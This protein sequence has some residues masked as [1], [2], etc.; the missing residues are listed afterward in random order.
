MSFKTFWKGFRI[1]AILILITIVVLFMYQNGLIFTPNHTVALVPTSL[2]GQAVETRIAQSTIHPGSSGEGDIATTIPNDI[3]LTMADADAVTKQL[4]RQ[5]TSK[6][7]DL[8]LA[9]NVTV[10]SAYTYCGAA[11]D[12]LSGD[13]PVKTLVERWRENT[14][15]IFPG[16]SY[17]VIEMGQGDMYAGIQNPPDVTVVFEEGPVV[18]DLVAH[19]EVHTTTI[20]IT[21]NAVFGM[22]G[23]EINPGNQKSAS[24]LPEPSQFG[25]ALVNVTTPLLG[26]KPLT[27]AEI[28][29]I[30]TAAINGLIMDLVAP[31]DPET[32]K[33]STVY[34]DYMYQALVKSFTQPDTTDELNAYGDI[35]AT[36]CKLAE[37]GVKADHQTNASL[38]SSCKLIVNL[39]WP[40]KPGVW[41]RL[42]S[43]ASATTDP[44]KLIPAINPANEDLLRN[45]LYLVLSNKVKAY[46]GMNPHPILSPEPNNW[47]IT[48]YWPSQP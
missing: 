46:R 19:Q 36:F 37:A 13:N 6:P 23:P 25:R 32:G 1:F 24:V 31:L 18:T 39:N 2:S 43:L 11:F 12:I 21:I 17:C 20:T 22:M 14:I 27:D 9:T 15:F 16:A 45:N 35:K 29:E 34:L 33:R 38:T 30:G 42:D 48:F 41:Y 3:V 8:H 44:S 4:Q 26:G 40:G 28:S 10:R 47:D 7:V 5:V